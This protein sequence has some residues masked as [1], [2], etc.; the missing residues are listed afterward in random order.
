MLTG[1]IAYGCLTGGTAPAQELNYPLAV[2]AA[3]DGTLYIAD[4][5]LPGVWK[6]TNGKTEVY[7][8]GSKKFR[9]PLNAVRCVAIDKQGRLLAGD[10]ATREVYRFDESA[11]PKPLTGGKMATSCPG[12]TQRFTSWHTGS[13]T[14]SESSRESAATK[15][16][17][18]ASRSS[19]YKST[20][21]GSIT[22]R[23]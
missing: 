10:S 14:G 4:R 7:F 21:R 9:T 22:A 16:S 17:K 2:A 18:D 13:T 19:D 5:Y 8:Q 3:D 1:L 12:T 15:A 11:K 6:V 23:R 20:W